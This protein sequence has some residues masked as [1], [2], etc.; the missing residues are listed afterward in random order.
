MF[1]V[2]LE[3]VWKVSEECFEDSLRVSVKCLSRVWNVYGKCLEGGYKDGVMWLFVWKVST[4]LGPKFFWTKDF[5]VL[6]CFRSQVSLIQIFV[7]PKISLNPKY[8][9]TQDFLKPK[10]FGTQIFSIL[11]IFS[12]LLLISWDHS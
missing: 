10:F 8:F 11:K 6:Q 12:E 5:W 7:G 3:G 9:G 1:E 2:C 4:F